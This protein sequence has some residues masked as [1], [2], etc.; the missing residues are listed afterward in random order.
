[1]DVELRHKTE[2]KL[3]QAQI[4]QLKKAVPKG[5]K[6]KKKE[7]DQQIAKLQTDLAHRQ[8]A[9]L[10]LMAQGRDL[11]E[12]DQYLAEMASK[13]ALAEA[14]NKTDTQ[15]AESQENLAE[16]SG[17]TQKENGVEGEDEE[18]HGEGSEEKAHKKS[19]AQ[20]RREKKELEESARR[21][22]VLEECKGKVSNK[23]VEDSAFNMLLRAQGLAVHQIPADG[24]CLYAAMAH[25]LQY[26]SRLPLGKIEDVKSLRHIAAS[27]IRRHRDEYLPYM[28]NDQGDMLSPDEFKT[29]CHKLETTN[30][31][32]G[33]LELR[34]L[35]E[36]LGEHIVVLQSNASPL[37]FGPPTPAGNEPLR[38]S[39]HRHTYG[40]G[41]HYNS[42]VDAGY[43]SDL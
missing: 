30:D 36:A 2:K 12:L 37:P 28:V 42:V 41:E 17:S 22:A 23:S 20:K 38:L 25:Q 29:Y 10:E 27:H 1:M 14:Q 9:E 5:D 31:W 8:K 34:A 16:N 18:T 11:S 21:A 40:L 24:H 32:G 43:A 3:L 7:I 4:M 39:Y 33:Q 26:R 15:P 13:M 19:K 6:K 35:A